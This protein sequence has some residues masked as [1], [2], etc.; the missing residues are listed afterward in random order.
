MRKLKI[1]I[2]DDDASYSLI[3]KGYLE[4]YLNQ[5]DYLGKIYLFNNALMFLNSFSSDYD[6][7]FLDIK[8]PFLNGIDCAKKIREI[9]E[10][11][12]IIFLTNLTQYALNGYDVGALDYLI[13]PLSQESFNLKFTKAL[14]HRPDNKLSKRIL[15]PSED[16]LVPVLQSDI[17]YLESDKHYVIYHTKKK[18]L[19][20]RLISLKNAYKELDPLNFAYCNSCYIV[21]LNYVEYING[22]E[23]KIAD[24]LI[25]ISHPKKKDFLR[26]YKEFS[27][28]E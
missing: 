20:R 28:R 18:L 14:K 15:L 26:C 9:D 16:K 11:V 3:I 25:L 10:K 4:S 7:I 1:A 21:N 27:Q 23:V 12:I 5:S 24:D 22:Y 2:V 8:M 13:K 19:Y 17:T 6:I